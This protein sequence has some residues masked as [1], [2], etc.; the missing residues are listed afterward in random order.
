MIQD[1]KLAG[2]V[3]GTQREYLRA[4]R[5]LAAKVLTV[6]A[7]RH[8]SLILDRPYWV[9]SAATSQPTRQVNPA[10]FEPPLAATAI[11]STDAMPVFAPPSQSCQ[12]RATPCRD[13]DKI[14]RRNACLRSS[15]RLR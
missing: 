14:D 10:N 4:V 13:C 1:M 5:Q 9:Y 3:E 15:L 2:L 7:A 12:F 6:R 11:K 8:R